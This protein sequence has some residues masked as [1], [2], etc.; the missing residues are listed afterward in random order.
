M[1]IWPITWTQS[2]EQSPYEC[3]ELKVNKAQAHTL[4]M[5]NSSISNHSKKKK[6]KKKI[7][8]L[9]LYYIFI[10]SILNFIENMDLTLVRIAATWLADQKECFVPP[11]RNVSFLPRTWN[12]TIQHFRPQRPLS[13][14]LSSSSFVIVKL[15]ISLH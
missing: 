4:P 2:D 14:I 15:P 13:G 6:K 12:L 3:V 7:T 9:K 8:T 5:K 11:S 1:T 10:K